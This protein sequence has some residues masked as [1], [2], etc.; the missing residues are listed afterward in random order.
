MT[1]LALTHT[2][3]QLVMARAGLAGAD[4]AVVMTLGALHAGHAELIRQARQR[5]AYVIVTI[6][7]IIVISYRQTI[8]RPTWSTRPVSRVCGSVPARWARCWR[9]TR[10]PG[11]S[12]GY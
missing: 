9:G 1:E 4:V 3:E 2:R 6:F 10:G 11:T 12:T 5:A 8:R 7:L